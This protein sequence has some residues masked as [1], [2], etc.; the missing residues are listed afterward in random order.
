MNHLW[1]DDVKREQDL[2]RDKLIQKAEQDEEREDSCL[3]IRI[4]AHQVIDPT[5]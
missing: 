2:L 1:N 4:P 3:D 5:E